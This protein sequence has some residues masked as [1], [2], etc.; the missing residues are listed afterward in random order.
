MPKVFLLY[1]ILNFKFY[2]FLFDFIFIGKDTAIAIS[3]ASGFG[4]K[5]G[6]VLENVIET[7]AGIYTVCSRRDKEIIRGEINES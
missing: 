2:L 3:G 7:V 6:S 1:F 5:G 4:D